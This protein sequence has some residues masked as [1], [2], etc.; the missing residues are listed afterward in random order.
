ML[1]ILSY[2]ILAWVILKPQSTHPVPIGKCFP[3]TSAPKQLCQGSGRKKG[4]KNS[5]SWWHDRKMYHNIQ[6]HPWHPS[7]FHDITFKSSN[8]HPYDYA[9][10]G[11]QTWLSGTSIIYIY[12]YIIPPYTVNIKVTR[13]INNIDYNPAGG[14][15]T[16]EKFKSIGM[17]IPNIW[18]NQ[19]HVPNHEP[20]IRWFPS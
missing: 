6:L 17:I 1:H 19:S 11:G 15:N 18:E 12:I 16:P 10:S 8:N 20:V 2:L 7:I 5:N 13:Y 9:P 4:N 3:I 14:F